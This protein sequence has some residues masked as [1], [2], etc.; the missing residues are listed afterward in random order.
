MLEADLSR[1]AAR[2]I[3]MSSA[4]ERSTALIKSKKTEL[5]KIQASIAN[6]KLLETFSGMSKWEK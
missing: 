3:T 6:A 1:T 2:L 5:H 4:E